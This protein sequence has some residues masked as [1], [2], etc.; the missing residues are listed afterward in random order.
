MNTELIQYAGKVIEG[1]FGLTNKT[2]EE[3]NPQKFADGVQTLA[4]GVGESYELMRK[5]V[6]ESTEFSD[7]EKI[8]KLK[9]LANSEIQ[10]K[11]ACGEILQ[12]NREHTANVIS[13][14]FEDFLSCGVSFAPALISQL[15]D[16]VA[17]NSSVETLHNA[18]LDKVLRRR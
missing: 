11:K 17:G 2:M 4:Q 12:G 16:S 6:L 13:N 1:I 15:K 8:E 14:V 18:V 5:I 10:S 3:S 9:D 7:T